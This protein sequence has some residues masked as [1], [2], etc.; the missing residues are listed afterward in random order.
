[1]FNL[2]RSQK[3]MVRLFLGG[4][5]TM[6]AFSMVVTLI[7]GLLSNPADPTELIIA[8]V[9]GREITSTNLAERLRLMGVRPDLPLRT[10]NLTSAQYTQDLIADQVLLNEAEALGLLPDEQELAEWLKFQLPFLFPDGVFVG[11]LAYTRYVQEAYRR[12]VPEFE[13]ELARDLAINTRLRRLVTA[14]EWV[15]NEDL[16]QAYR[17]RHNKAKIEFVKVSVADVHKRV[18]VTE[19]KL[20]EFYE[21]RKPTYLIDENRTAKLLTVSDAVLPPP[22]VAEADM[23][24][25]Y[26][27]NLVVYQNPER[28][29]TRHILF[30]T[31]DKSEEESAA[32]EETAKKVL[33]E[34]RAGG[35]FVKL[36]AQHSED[37]ASAS[38]GGDL[39]WVTRGQMDPEFEKG[40]FALKAGEISELVK[41]TFGFHIIKADAREDGGTKPFEEVQEQVREALRRER[42][43]L[44]RIKLL[45]EVMAAARGSGADLE[46]VGRQFNLPVRTVGPF[47]LAEPAPELATPQEFLNEVFTAEV[48]EPLS[49]T[50]E[51]QVTI[52]VLSEINRPRQAEFEDV[53]DQVRAQFL[54]AEGTAL[55][56]ERAYE[57]AEEAGK[58]GAILRRV[59]AR[60]GLKTEVSPFFKTIEP[61]LNLGPARLLG[62]APF[63]SEPGTLLGPVPVEGDF[64]VYQ[65]VAHEEADLL[66]FE[67]EK[68]SIR[69]TQLDQKRNQAFEVYKAAMVDRYM[70][71]KRVARYDQRVAEFALGFSRRGG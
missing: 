38:D 32:I 15:S 60:Y 11:Q 64:V 31:L 33:E 8:E 44:S 52:V 23:R 9:D 24:R 26:N 67:D 20:K 61:V 18:Q 56:S 29:Q 51:S 14:N 50:K 47:T 53:R 36:A 55:A 1:M 22:E 54:D 63:K 71:E 35:D 66:A 69:K 5:L 62:P 17:D 43:H 41:S 48:G 19:E 70:Q 12:S 45:D 16:E 21:Q 42:L 49:S 6:V 4:L 46:E 13:A 65:V 25:H 27:Q 59:A 40:T 3:Q 68:E 30:M 37:P 57:I 7:P 34:V 2:F 39:G 28:V 58:E 10:L